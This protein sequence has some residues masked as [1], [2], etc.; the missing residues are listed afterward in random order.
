MILLDA[1][2]IVSYLMNNDKDHVRA[3]KISGKIS[4]KELVITNAILIETMNL[5]TKN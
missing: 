3:L 5:L 4:K 1:S 2:F